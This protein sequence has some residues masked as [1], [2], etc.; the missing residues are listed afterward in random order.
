MFTFPKELITHKY[1]QLLNITSD[2][3]FSESFESIKKL[4]HEYHRTQF[5]IDLLYQQII[6]LTICY[7]IISDPDKHQLYNQYGDYLFDKIINNEHFDNKL[8]NYIFQ[9]PEKSQEPFFIEIPLEKMNSGTNLSIKY[10]LKSFSKK[11]VNMDIEIPKRSKNNDSITVDKGK[12]KVNIFLKQKRNS[13][14]LTFG[15]NL[16]SLVNV[17]IYDILLRKDYIFHNFYGNKL[18][19]KLADL[20]PWTINEYTNQGLFSNNNKRRASLFILFNIK[21]PQRIDYQSELLLKLLRQQ[22]YQIKKIDIVSILETIFREQ[23][24]RKITPLIQQESTTI[25]TD[26]IATLKKK[27]KTA[28][29]NHIYKKMI[30]TILNNNYIKK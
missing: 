21:Y 19:I 28:D 27:Y 16:L 17:S 3:P 10:Q 1:Y 7:T 9:N 5:N 12:N 2:T 30:Y 8:L 13:Q 24:P 6:T 14:F 22:D 18:T 23:E 11:V 15:H 20:R 4:Y 26:F 25:I 29:E